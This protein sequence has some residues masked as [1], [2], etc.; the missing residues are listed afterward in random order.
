M[1]T[2]QSLHDPYVQVLSA[3]L[4]DCRQGG[5]GEVRFNSPFTPPG[6][7]YDTKLHLY[8]NLSKKVFFDQ[9]SEV[10]GSLSYLFRFLGEEY[11]ED[12]APPRIS[13]AEELRDRLT[14]LSPPPWKTPRAELPEWYQTITPG[15]RVQEYLWGRGVGEEDI[16][17]TN[18]KP[19]W[20]DMA[21]P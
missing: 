21:L 1:E 10:S 5:S 6:K 12:P 15:G 20:Q 17:F 3:A 16:E 19:M 7:D 14:A 2:R 13:Y 4:G 11:V 9:R 8:V 18:L